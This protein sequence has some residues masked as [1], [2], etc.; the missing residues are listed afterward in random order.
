MLQ[1]LLKPIYTYLIFINSYLPNQ[2]I[3]FCMTLQQFF[4][5]LGDNPEVILFF[6]IALPLTA[7]LALVFGRG[8]GENTPWKEL[9]GLLV[10]LACL[11]G[12]FAITLNAYLFLFER[13]SI[14]QTNIYTQILP[15]LSMVLTLWIIRRN[16]CFEDIPGFDRLGG[17][18]AMILV[19]FV[20]MWILEK[21]HIFVISIMPF[22][23]FIILL[24]VILVMVR[25]GWK[26]MF[27]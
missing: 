8:Q 12:I 11:P 6:F 23:Y 1:A 14:M 22:S 27:K 20:L 7:A 13:Q 21:T 4:Q 2:Y 26:A 19:L 15:I 3:H 18:V 9:Y 10:Y 5:L 24:V 25:F 17:L 16:I